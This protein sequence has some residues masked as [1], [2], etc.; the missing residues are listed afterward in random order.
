MDYEMIAEA[1]REYHDGDYE[2]EGWELDDFVNEYL[3]Q[4]GEAAQ[5]FVDNYEDPYAWQQDLIDMRRE[6]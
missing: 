3:R 1:V 4:A 5:E 6:M 2:S